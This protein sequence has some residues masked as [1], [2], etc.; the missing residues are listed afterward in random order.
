MEDNVGLAKN[1]TFELKSE[2]RVGRT[3]GRVSQAAGM[4]EAKAGGALGGHQS[5]VCE[6]TGRS[7]QLS[8]AVA[9][10][11]PRPAGRQS[12][13]RLEASSSGQG[14]ALDTL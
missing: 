13:G 12:L 14:A 8:G 7:C 6:G 5:G 3:R 9:L 1:R 2:R 11:A 10:G 4:T